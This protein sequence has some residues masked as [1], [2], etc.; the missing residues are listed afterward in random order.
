M[1]RWK[2]YEVLHIRTDSPF[3]DRHGAYPTRWLA[4]WAA[5]RHIQRALA[6]DYI[7]PTYAVREIQPRTRP[8]YWDLLQVNQARHWYQLPS[9][10]VTA[11][12]EIVHT[13]LGFTRWHALGR[14]C[15]WAKPR[16]RQQVRLIRWSDEPAFVPD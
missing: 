11:G 4:N 8:P 15:H 1:I 2:R 9:A 7:E 16:S 10:Q 13:S 5:A 14:A 12:S 3:Q 6:T